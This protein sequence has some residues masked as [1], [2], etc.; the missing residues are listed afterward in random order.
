[1]TTKLILSVAFATIAVIDSKSQD[2]IRIGATHD[3]D[4]KA[5]IQTFSLDFNRSE[6]VKEK[7]GK[8]LKFSN[9]NVYLLPTSDINIGDGITSSENNILTTINAGKGYFGKVYKM[10]NDSSVSKVFNYAIEV[11]PSYNSDKNFA[12]K[13]VFGQ[14]KWVGNFIRSKSVT[15]SDSDAYVKNARMFSVA[16]FSNIGYRFS[17]TYKTGNNYSTIGL[18]FDYKQRLLDSDRKEVWIFSLNFSFYRILSEVEKVKVEDNAGMIKASID[19]KL[20][21]NSYIGLGYKY[22]NDNPNYK[23]VNV[24]EFSVK[25]KY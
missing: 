6:S 4:K 8:F 18:L 1:M 13:L 19:K 16:V 14:L 20:I 5:I 22:G 24:L 11:N 10:P 15:L 2:F 25:M 17:E 23:Y 9:D 3:F 21:K 12:E 7:P